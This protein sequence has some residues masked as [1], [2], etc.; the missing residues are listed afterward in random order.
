MA[1]DDVRAVEKKLA[2]ALA[3]KWKREN[4]EMCGYVRVQMSI[5]VARSNTMLLRGQQKDRGIVKRPVHKD[6]AGVALQQYWRK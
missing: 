6:G 2:S 1:G 3:G 4:S 5:A